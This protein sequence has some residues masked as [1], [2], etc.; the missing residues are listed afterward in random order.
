M[1]PLRGAGERKESLRGEEGVAEGEGPRV[2]RERVV[3]EEEGGRLALA[4]EEAEEG[5]QLRPVREV[6]AAEEEEEV[7]GL[8][9]R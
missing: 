9:S 4:E 1:A 8:E 7:A 2:G 3:E 5:A 6:Q